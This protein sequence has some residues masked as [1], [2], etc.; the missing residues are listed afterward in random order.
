MMPA[1]EDEVREHIPDSPSTSSSVSS[2]TTGTPPQ[3]ATSRR[4]PIAFAV[5]HNYR[6]G[7]GRDFERPIVVARSGSPTTPIDLTSEKLKCSRVLG[8]SWE[9]E[10]DKP[11]WAS[12]AVADYSAANTQDSFAPL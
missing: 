12:S 7:S 5:G 2:P 1:D 6:Y 4:R 8:S 10:S 9:I 11:S 3:M